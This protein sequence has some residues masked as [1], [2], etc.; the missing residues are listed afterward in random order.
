MVRLDVLGPQ[1]GNEIAFP[2]TDVHKP[3]LGKRQGGKRR[4]WKFPVQTR[5]IPRVAQVRDEACGNV[6]IET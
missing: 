1:K 6:V 5:Q 4:G 2:N 3:V